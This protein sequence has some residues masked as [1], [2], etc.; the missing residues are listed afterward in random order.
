MEWILSVI[1]ESPSQLL[2]VPSAF[3]F[4]HILASFAISRSGTW[5]GPPDRLIWFAV[6]VSCL[7]AWSTLLWQ[8]MPWGRISD[9]TIANIVA[10]PDLASQIVPSLK[11]FFLFYLCMYAY[12]TVT[13]WTQCSIRNAAF[14]IRKTIS[15]VLIVEGMIIFYASPGKMLLLASWQ[16]LFTFTGCVFDLLMIFQEVL[17]LPLAE[18][19]RFWRRWLHALLLLAS[20]AYFLLPICRPMAS[21]VKN[22]AIGHGLN[23]TKILFMDFTV[24]NV[25]TIVCIFVVSLFVVVGSF[26]EL[27]RKQKIE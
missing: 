14:W 2:L 26:E 16:M 5:I 13:S 1:R 4:L 17:I 23:D 15:A 18:H 9:N 24:S 7:S 12:Q 11:L 22:L 25:P 8:I 20:T 27:P 21:L 6:D 19:E 3:I 10:N